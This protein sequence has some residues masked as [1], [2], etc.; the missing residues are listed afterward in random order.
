[1]EAHI[2]LR[3]EYI[4]NHSKD[5]MATHI[6]LHSYE[7]ALVVHMTANGEINCI[8]KSVPTYIA[9]NLVAHECDAHSSQWTASICA[10]TVCVCDNIRQ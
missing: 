2:R 4:I 9:H 6:T 7:M 10:R 1:M 5:T 8:H 3:R